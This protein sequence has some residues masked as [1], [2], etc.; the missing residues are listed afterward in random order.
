MKAESFQSWLRVDQSGLYCKPGGFY[1]D[2]HGPVGRAIITHGHSDHARPGNDKVLATKETLAVM[3]A[4]LG[5][6]GRSSQEAA[7]G[8]T[9]TLGDTRVTL[10][11]AGHVLGS[12]QV[13]IEYEGRRAVISGDYKR[14]PDP[15]C[16]AFELV[17][18]DLFVTEATF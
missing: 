1:V 14:A 7:Y 9:L 15:T 2:P 5:E 18:C 6:A 17:P 12:A 16:S 4:R 10:M 11:P 8:E 3:R 13:V